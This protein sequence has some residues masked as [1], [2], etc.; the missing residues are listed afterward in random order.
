MSLPFIGREH[1]SRSDDDRDG[2]GGRRDAVSPPLAG[3]GVA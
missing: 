1:D 2:A 3:A